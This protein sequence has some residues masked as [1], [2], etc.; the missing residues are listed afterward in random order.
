MG[1][2]IVTMILMLS[3]SGCSQDKEIPQG[4]SEQSYTDFT[5]IYSNYQEAKKTN[6]EY[7]KAFSILGKYQEKD[8]NGKLTIQESKVSDALADLLF[9]YN[10]HILFK[11]KRDEFNNQLDIAKYGIMKNEQE[12]KIPVLENTIEKIL[13]LP[14]TTSEE[15]DTNN[16]VD[17]TEAVSEENCP[18]PYTKE[19]CENFKDYYTN[20]EG[21]FE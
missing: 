15:N 13:E 10:N 11:Y 18:Q 21:Q 7:K 19:D 12:N 5:K 16:Q 8:E 14:R 3:I 20:G 17:P 9:R 1:I 6:T 2:L 4:F